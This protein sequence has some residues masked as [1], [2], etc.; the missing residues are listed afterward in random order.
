MIDQESPGADGEKAE[1]TKLEQGDSE[2]AAAGPDCDD[3]KAETAPEAGVPVAEFGAAPAPPE[4]QVSAPASAPQSTPNTFS[5]EPFQ[6]S[7]L[8]WVAAS[9]FVPFGTLAI[10]LMVFHNAFSPKLCLRSGLVGTVVA[11]VIFGLWKLDTKITGFR[12]PDVSTQLVLRMLA[13]MLWLVWVGAS[14]VIILATDEVY[15]PIDLTTYVGA[16]HLAMDFPKRQ[17]NANSLKVTLP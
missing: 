3:V 14:H 8:W 7:S 9:F 16:P 17:L 4:G 15:P 2:A 6:L 1:N 13:M 5:K 11:V 10:Y 12:A